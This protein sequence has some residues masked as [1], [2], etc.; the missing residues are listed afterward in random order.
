MVIREQLALL[1]KRH[2]VRSFISINCLQ[3][4]LVLLLLSAFIFCSAFILHLINYLIVYFCFL[5][6]LV[7]TMA[8]FLLFMWVLFALLLLLLLLHFSLTLRF[9][10]KMSA[11]SWLC[12]NTCVIVIGKTHK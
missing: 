2:V 7:F 3:A 1:Y 5:Y 6:H 9:L 4:C 10:H 8:F 11:I 12:T